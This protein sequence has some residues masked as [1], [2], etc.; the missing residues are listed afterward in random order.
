MNFPT[1]GCIA[2]FCLLFNTAS[3]V[4]VDRYGN[5]TANQQL[6]DMS[7]KQS[8]EGLEM[9]AKA[10]AGRLSELNVQLDALNNYS[11][12]TMSPEEVAAMEAWQKKNAQE[13]DK[14]NAEVAEHNMRVAMQRQARFE[15]NNATVRRMFQRIVPLSGGRHLGNI[16]P[17]DRVLAAQVAQALV[18]GELYRMDIS[19]YLPPGDQF[20][21]RQ[22]IAQQL[23]LTLPPEF[24]SDKSNLYAFRALG[25][26]S[27]R[28][29]QEYHT[30]RTHQI[31]AWNRSTETSSSDYLF[32]VLASALA[33]PT[34]PLPAPGQ[35]ELAMA[36]FTERVV[37]LSRNSGLKYMNYEINLLGCM[38]QC[39]VRQAPELGRMRRFTGNQALVKPHPQSV[40]GAAMRYNSDVADDGK[41]WVVT[42]MWNHAW[43]NLGV[44]LVL[45]EPTQFPGPWFSD[46]RN[47][48]REKHLRP[49]QPFVKATIQKA[50]DDWFVRSKATPELRQVIQADCDLACDAQVRDL[51]PY[52]AWDAAL[53]R[54]ER[55]EDPR[56]PAWMD[57]VNARLLARVADHVALK[58]IHDATGWKDDTLVN[59]PQRAALL[60]LLP[61]LANCTDP[62]LVRQLTRMG[63]CNEDW[64]GLVAWLEDPR[65]RPTGPVGD[66]LFDDYQSAVEEVTIT[67]EWLETNSLSWT[68]TLANLDESTRQWLRQVE[69]ASGQVREELV[70]AHFNLLLAHKDEEAD[71][72]RRSRWLGGLAP[73]ARRESPVAAKAQAAILDLL[74]RDEIDGENTTYN[75]IRGQIMWEQAKTQQKDDQAAFA[76][77]AFVIRDPEELAL[78]SQ[79]SNYVW[80]P[81]NPDPELLRMAQNFS[82]IFPPIPAPAAKLKATSP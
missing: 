14:Q 60:K 28:T 56:H 30:L 3:A 38:V 69:A 55:A 5:R 7:D 53:R 17:E 26:V 80:L 66:Q 24:I 62:A 36:L 40:F 78:L 13:I 6:Q 64:P 73:L 81:L 22:F 33:A 50:L 37:E 46:M 68:T 31:H 25:S 74:D 54:D 44:T 43:W 32:M 27:G 71:H 16:A 70:T 34:N 82:S 9:S 49:A 20:Y 1:L 79:W 58:R 12:Q 21:D 45:A 63:V 42:D 72:S 41:P 4:E 67:R 52:Q 48:R 10:R 57:S 11:S 76:A 15:E 23:Y 65:R 47:Y 75:L 18:T 19:D 59:A 2:L 51:S 61:D 29:V 8:A 35:R 39:A 77:V